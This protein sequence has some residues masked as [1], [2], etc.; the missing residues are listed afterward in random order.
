ML[1]VGC[2]GGSSPARIA[3]PGCTQAGGVAASPEQSGL[4]LVSCN[5]GCTSSGCSINQIAQNQPA[6]L[7]FNQDIDPASVTTASLSLRT[8]SGEQP[9]GRLLVNGPVV[10]FVPEVLTVGAQSFFGFRGGETYTM[11]LPGGSAEINAL[12]ASSGDPLIST[13]TC[14]LDISGGIVDLDEQPPRAR[15]VSPGA[16]FGVPSASTI[17]IEFSEVISSASFVT[18]TAATRPVQILVRTTIPGAGSNPQCDPQSPTTQVFGQWDLENDPVSQVTRATFRP[19]SA[20]PGGV[21][22][23]VN[24]TSAVE[25]LSGKPAQGQTFTYFTLTERK[26]PVELV[27]DFSNDLNL[28]REY[29]SGEWSD[30][31]AKPGPIGMTGQ[32]GDFDYRMGDEVEPNVFEW[33]TDDFSIPRTFTVNGEKNW[34]LS[35]LDE[36][37]TDGVF[38]F[39][40]FTIPPGVTVRFVGSRPAR[41]FVRG[42]LEVLGQLDVAGQ[43]QDR[44]DGR[45]SMGQPGGL[46]GA[47]GGPAGAGGGGRGANQGDGLGPSPEFDGAPG[48]TVQVQAG[49]AYAGLEVGSAGLGSGQYPP[50]GTDQEVVDRFA[51]LQPLELSAQI[52][53][54]GGGAGFATDGQPGTVVMSPLGTHGDDGGAGTFFGP[55]TGVPAAPLLP[56]PPGVT[57]FDHLLVGGSGGGGAGSHPFGSNHTFVLASISLWR[58]GGGGGGGGGSLGLRVGGNFSL[59]EDAVITAA[60]GSTADSTYLNNLGLPGGGGSGGSLVVQVGGLIDQQGTLDVSGGRGGAASADGVVPGL[61]VKS[62]DGSDGYLRLETTGTPD[63]SLLGD[64]ARVLPGPTVPSVT[65]DAL[66]EIDAVSGARSLWYSSGQV[67]PPIFL[68]YEIDVSVDGQLQRYSDDPTQGALGAAGPTAPVE[69]LL[70]GASLTPAGGVDPDTVRPWRAFAGDH[71]SAGELSL[72]NDRPQAV[73][74]LL[75]FHQVP[76]GPTVEVERLALW[77]QPF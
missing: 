47:N 35:G 24:I 43:S 42:E 71:G 62:G 49:H 3:A 67:F 76:G 20:I 70:Q 54:G 66:T 59:D 1:A 69:L 27:E 9:Q 51:A 36:R 5:L 29:S 26:D 10:Q 31:T 63:P 28:D 4:C 22:V 74:F 6:T 53:A 30:G 48:D 15:L 64:P 23:D 68:R 37:I 44:W 14:S 34:T 57:V 7:V 73:R 65:V 77:F 55:M 8:A 50:G 61:S 19:D 17:V 33:S 56:I 58:S 13:Y 60:G 2:S 12:R 72:N 39:S 46:S 21:C 38:E 32:L 18:S 16:Q 45:D 52:A 40:R 75:L 11:R 41:V 25:D